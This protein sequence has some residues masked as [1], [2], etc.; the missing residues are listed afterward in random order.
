VS[1]RPSCVAARRAARAASEALLP[2]TKWV[3]QKAY[4][5]LGLLREAKRLP[6]GLD[7]AIVTLEAFRKIEAD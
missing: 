4:P 3:E 6:G 5:V 1:R 7:T 2:A